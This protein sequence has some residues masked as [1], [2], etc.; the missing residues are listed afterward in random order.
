MSF[1]W[2]YSN[3]I[4]TIVMIG[5]QAYVFLTLAESRFDRKKTRNMT[6]IFLVV[7]LTICIGGCRIMMMPERDSNWSLISLTLPAVG[8]FL[9]LSKYRGFRFVVT[10]C[11]SDV[12]IALLDFMGHILAWRFWGFNQFY[13]TLISAIVDVVGAFCVH[14][15]IGNRYRRALNELKKGWGIMLVVTVLF[16]G[17]MCV[18]ASYPNTITERPEDYMVT[19]LILFTMEVVVLVIVRVIF[20]M[21]ELRE[22]ERNEQILT[23]QI[24]MAHLQY[25]ALQQNMDRIRSIK[26][27]LSYH[28]LVLDGLLEKQDYDGVKE[29]LSEL[30]KVTTDAVPVYCK[31]YIAN[32]LLAHYVNK[33]KEANIDFQFKIDIPENIPKNAMHL[34]VVLGNAWNNAIEACQKVLPNNGKRYIYTNAIYSDNN[35]I[36]HCAN[37]YDGDIHLVDGVLVSNKEGDHGQG[38]RNICCIAEMY[39]GYCRYR[40]TDTE[41]VLDVVMNMELQPKE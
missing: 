6:L 29:Y 24:H 34:S 20:F 17:V 10:Y 39:H 30:E 35:I 32:I 12:S 26:H 25:D 11:M 18:L 37:S 31:N 33:T 21:L 36:F 15:V 27:D 23:E 16:Y 14:F 13:V 1:E 28:V 41:F 40:Y 9:W 22:K 2:W 7:I 19:A 8:Y 38:I 3:L 5:T 4:Q